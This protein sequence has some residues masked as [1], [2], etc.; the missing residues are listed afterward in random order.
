MA[1]ALDMAAM[2]V[3]AKVG[4]A[5]KARMAAAKSLATRD[6][7]TAAMVRVMARVMPRAMPRATKV[8]VAEATTTLPATKEPATAATTRA[9]TA[10]VRVISISTRWRW[11]SNI[12]GSMPDGM[13]PSA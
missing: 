9:D 11:L 2:A 13:L 8:Q 3:M 12:S 7:A 6:P 10:V 5:A 1:A 4:K